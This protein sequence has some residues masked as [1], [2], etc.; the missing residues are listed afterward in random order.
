MLS[1]LLKY[2]MISTVLLEFYKS[3]TLL[4]HIWVIIS[5]LSNFTRLWIVLC[6]MKPCGEIRIKDLNALV[7]LR[8]VENAINNVSM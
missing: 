2:R 5:R 1:I 4:L 7:I 8:G 3:L 6:V